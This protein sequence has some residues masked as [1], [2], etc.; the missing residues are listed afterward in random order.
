MTTAPVFRARNLSCVFENSGE[1]VRAVSNVSMEIPS[2]RIVLVNGASGSGKTTLLNLLGGLETPTSGQVE[3][4]GHDISEFG[5]ARLTMWRRREIAF[6]FQAFAL[7]PGLTARENIDLPLRIAGYAPRE[8][9]DRVNHYLELV[10]LAARADHRVFELSG[11]EQQRVAIARALVKKPRVVLADE[12]TG[13]L[14][15]KTCIKVLS[16]FRRLVAEEDLT[17]VTTSHDP[18]ARQFSNEVHTLRD[19]EIVERDVQDV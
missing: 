4:E 11:G 13:G 17:I 16:L 10:G 8:I 5:Q 18:I 2:Q 15:R 14:D 7:L 1:A 9:V 6:V 3:Y 12:P 19:G